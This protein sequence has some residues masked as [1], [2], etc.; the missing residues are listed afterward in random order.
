MGQVS[1]GGVLDSDGCHGLPG[2][3]VRSGAPVRWSAHVT[4]RRDNQTRHYRL[5]IQEKMK[6]YDALQYI[7]MY[8]MYL[9]LVVMPIYSVVDGPSLE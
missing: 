4:H 7:H 2:V 6:L 1:K 3:G 8:Y 9:A 5:Y